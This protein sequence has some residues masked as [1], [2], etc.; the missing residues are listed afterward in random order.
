[1]SVPVFVNSPVPLQYLAN[2]RNPN[3]YVRAR[4]YSISDTLLATRDLAHVEDGRYS[5][6]TYLMPNADVVKV[7]YDPYKDAGYTKFAPCDGSMDQKFTKLEL[8]QELVRNDEIVAIFEESDES[9]NGLFSDEQICVTIEP[10]I[11][12][13]EG[14]ISDEAITFT[15][16]ETDGLCA[17]IS[18]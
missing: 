17:V 18:C 10:N 12:G 5:D 6:F 8:N 13:I 7:R 15:V 14:V 1:M 4:I 16:T 2:D 3:L 11:T 9:L